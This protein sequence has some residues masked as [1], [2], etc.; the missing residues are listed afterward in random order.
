MNRNATE[1]ATVFVIP[2]ANTN[3]EAT[4]GVSVG[5]PNGA[6][7][8]NTEPEFVPMFSGTRQSSTYLVNKNKKIH[9][10][11]KPTLASFS[12]RNFFNLI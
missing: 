6:N 1:D 3:A 7:A 2:K 5:G 10:Y 8:P 9:N 4:A 12:P 11:F